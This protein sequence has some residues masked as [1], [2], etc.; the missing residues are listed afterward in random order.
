MLL[1]ELMFLTQLFLFFI[2]FLIKLFNLFNKGE[3][4]DIKISFVLLFLG[5]ICYAVGLL[6]NLTNF[7]KLILNVLFKFESLFLVLLVMFTLFELFFLFSEIARS[8]SRSRFDKV[9]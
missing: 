7:N 6:S 5:I 3:F 8:N 2:I 1:Y 9:T 4:Y